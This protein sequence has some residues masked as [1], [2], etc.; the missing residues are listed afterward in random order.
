MPERAGVGAILLAAGQSRRMGSTNKLL[1]R[2]DGEPMV[3]RAAR[4]LLDSRAE[5][6]VAV[7]G[8]QADA[9]AEA[10]SGLPLRQVRNA[11]HADGQMTSVRCGLASLPD[12]Y[13]GILV[14]L[15]DQPG[16]T[17]ADIDFVIDAFDAGDGRHIVVPVR[18]GRRGNP[19][20]LA[21]GLKAD[22]EGRDL[23]FGCRNLMAR[24]PHLVQG[25]EAP[26][27]RYLG[28]IDTPGDFAAMYRI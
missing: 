26:D 17:P 2:I 16:L 15:A 1:L 18:D 13:R 25:V 6:V 22:F 7:L 19:I 9:V 10:L 11:A 12:R 21:A 3:R 14:G 28:D 24:H 5:E 20:V 27:D 8:H 4:T 23:N